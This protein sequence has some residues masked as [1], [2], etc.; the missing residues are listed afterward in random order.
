MSLTTDQEKLY[1]IQIKECKSLADR[2]FSGILEVLDKQ[3]LRGQ[4]E[5]LRGQEFRRR[6]QNVLN[7]ISELARRNVPLDGACDV[8]MMT[9]AENRLIVENIDRSFEGVTDAAVIR[10]KRSR[11]ISPC[12]RLRHTLKEAMLLLK[13]GGY[14]NKC[15]KT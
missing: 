1:D 5:L 3:V 4:T 15:H 2:I 12:M 8:I 13:S 14:V 11:L 6:V 10:L 9:L 7:N